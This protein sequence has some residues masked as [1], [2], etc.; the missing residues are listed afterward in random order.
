MK[1]LSLNLR[2][3]GGKRIPA[4]LTYIAE[5][6][7]DVFIASEYRQGK[8][9][10]AL[11]GG[12]EDLGIGTFRAAPAD[13]HLTNGVLIAARARA[14]PV[15]LNPQP[16]RHDRHRIAGLQLPSVQIL[17]LYFANLKAKHSLFDFLLQLPQLEQTP[18]L[19]VGDFN[20]GSHHRDEPG[21]IFHCADKFDRLV[22]NGWSDLWR[23]RHGDA[24][25]E[26]TW[27]SRTGNGF[28]LDHALANPSAVPF[29]SSCHYDHSTRD[30]IS[31]HSAVVL[32][33]RF[34]P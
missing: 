22:G 6:S 27:Y 30:G 25:R 26:Y 7:P 32:E 14:A 33:T 16:Q 19:L 3:G 12:L 4:I 18:C 31:D 28:R 24:A 34:R 8:T 15:T 13:N 9:G 11:R 23:A 20:T 2:H 29:I 17:G 10:A 21:T 5:Q 1:I